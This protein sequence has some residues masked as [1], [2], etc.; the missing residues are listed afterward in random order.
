MIEMSFGPTSGACGAGQC[1]QRGAGACFEQQPVRHRGRPGRLHQPQRVEVEDE[2]GL[3]RRE[4]PAAAAQ[5]IAL[6]VAEH[7]Q[8]VLRR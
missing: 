4:S 3:G 6:D 2:G 5:A 1:E 8:P 7:V